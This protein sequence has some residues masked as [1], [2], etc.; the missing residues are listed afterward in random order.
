MSGRPRKAVPNK[1]TSSKKRI[2]RQEHGKEDS[3]NDQAPIAGGENGPRPARLHRAPSPPL[4]NQWFL[5][6]VESPNGEKTGRGGFS[7]ARGG[8]TPTARSRLFVNC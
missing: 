2:L 5:Q 4:S 1:L 7:P 6:T 8:F 3:D